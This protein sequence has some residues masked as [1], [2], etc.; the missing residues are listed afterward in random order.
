MVR[1]FRTLSVFVCISCIT[2]S[3]HGAYVLE[4][5]GGGEIVV[6]EYWHEEGEIRYPRYGGVVGIPANEVRQIRPGGELSL[7]SGGMSTRATGL[8]PAAPQPEEAIEA[9]NIEGSEPSIQGT[10]GEMRYMKEFE[11]RHG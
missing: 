7:E 6:N 8:V 11:A 5:K 2:C 10:P 9:R 1:A 4:L 3:A